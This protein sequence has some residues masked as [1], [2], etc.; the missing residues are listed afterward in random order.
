MVCYRCSGETEVFNSRTQKRNNQIWRRRRCVACG[1][2]FTTHELI[3]I[4]AL[5]SVRGEDGP[6]PF[7]PDRLLSELIVVLRDRTRPYETAK[8]LCATIMRN[9]LKNASDGLIS[10]QE[11]SR[12]ASKVLK[13]Y[14][15][16]AWL[17]YYAEHPSLQS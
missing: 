10:P 6:M 1:A 13:R 5:F 4:S 12:Q 2:V 17:R 7:T 8:E 15:K 11:I 16:Q 3:D 9:I 14:D